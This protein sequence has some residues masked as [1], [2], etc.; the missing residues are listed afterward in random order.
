MFNKAKRALEP[1]KVLDPLVF[2]PLELA[3]MICEHLTT[4]DRVCVFPFQGLLG[5]RPKTPFRICLAVSNPWKRLLELS[6]KLWTTLDT[7]YA[8]KPI[9]LRSLKAHLRRSKYTTDVAIITLRAGLD[10]QKMTYLMSSCK[11][12][13]RL[14]IHGSGVIGDSLTK[15]LTHSRSI[16]KLYVS[17]SCQITFSAIEEALKASRNTVADATFLQVRTR[18]MADFYPSIDFPR[19]DSLKRLRLKAQNGG[20]INLVSP[21]LVSS[22]HFCITSFVLLALDCVTVLAD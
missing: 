5:Y 15:S 4:R 10:I 3:Q 7:T 19:F 11:L 17:A 12:L 8:R 16:E 2:L 14:E 20:I 6:H 9:N 22:H 21:F 13:R 1:Q 18:G